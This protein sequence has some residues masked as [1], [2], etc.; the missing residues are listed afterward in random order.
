MPDL[1]PKYSDL[2]L[3]DCSP[4][5]ITSS[6]SDPVLHIIRKGGANFATLAGKITRQGKTSLIE[7]ETL[8]HDWISDDK[9]IR[10]L[11][12]DS[13]DIAASLLE[14]LNPQDLTYPQILSL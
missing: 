12:A 11:P 13:P 6:L 4:L 5:K 14:G 8:S 1:P 9:F 3:E 2:D 10:P 7:T